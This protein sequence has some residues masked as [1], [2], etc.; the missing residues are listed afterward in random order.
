MAATPKWDD[1]LPARGSSA[2]QSASE[3]ERSAALIHATEFIDLL[4]FKGR[5]L[6]DKQSL[7]W[8]RTGV[9]RDDGATITGVPQEIK[10]AT[11][12]VA[13]FILAKVPFD[14][15]AVAWVFAKIGHLL[16]DETNLID[17]AIPWH[18]LN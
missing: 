4:P 11:A 7:A 3:Q 8:P 6:S 10:E 2:W 15:P 12:L 13:G 5:R 16:K 14:V 9:F 18:K 1:S 17:R